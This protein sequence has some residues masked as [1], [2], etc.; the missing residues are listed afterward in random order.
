MVTFQD[1]LNAF[2]EYK[3]HECKQTKDTLWLLTDEIVG[4]LVKYEIKGRRID[5][6]DL[7]DTIQDTTTTLMER[8]LLAHF[9]DI[10]WIESRVAYAMR[11]AR[12]KI[13][14]RIEEREHD[15]FI[16]IILN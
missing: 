6:D 4:V 9:A 7:H 14:Y 12:K 2:N 10:P 1:I 13:K 16:E 5:D 15:D 11:D 3:Q 8:F